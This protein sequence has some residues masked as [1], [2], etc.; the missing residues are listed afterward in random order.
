MHIID[1]MCVAVKPSGA[2]V[3]A[4]GGSGEDRP[5]PGDSGTKKSFLEPSLMSD[6]IRSCL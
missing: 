3:P 1:G 6:E 2:R 5:Q 4:S